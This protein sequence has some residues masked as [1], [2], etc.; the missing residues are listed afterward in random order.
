MRA[1]LQV[2]HS[3]GELERLE[4]LGTWATAVVAVAA[5]WF[6]WVQI[7][8]ARRATQEATQP[9]VVAMFES[10]PV[11]PQ[12]IELAVRNFGSTP[13]RDV[14]IAIEPKPRRT[15]GGGGV[16]D[17][18]VPSTI[19]FLAP[20]QE[21]RTTWDFAPQRASSPELGAEDRH[22][23]RVSCTGLART[24]RRTTESV[25]DWSA[26]K[27]R[28][29]L[30]IKTVHHAAKSLRAVERLL[31]KWSEG[32]QGMAVLVRDGDKFDADEKAEYDAYV[33]SKQADQLQPGPTPEPGES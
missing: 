2:Q 33:A 12:V 22:V 16:Q 29:Y 31:T 3:V 15:M 30:D 14:T 9:N 21:W 13:A 11:T 6:V 24:Q 32:N 23:A 8:D 5:A 27:G 28:R 17:V 25:L 26:F 4:A 1:W 7:R 18:W 10:N 19:P 20:G